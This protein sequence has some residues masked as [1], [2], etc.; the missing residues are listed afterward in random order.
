MTDNRDTENKLKELGHAI[1]TDETTL[2]KVMSFV[3]TRH[4][5]SKRRGTSLIWRVIMNRPMIKLS[6]A[7]II[8]LA[9]IVAIHFGG[10]SNVAFANVKQAVESMPLVHKT[11]DTHRNGKHYHSET[12]YA[13]ETRTVVSKYLVDGRCFKISS[14]NYDTMENYAYDPNTD[15]VKR[16]YRTDV[17]TN[18]LSDS[19]WSMV[20]EHLQE[21]EQRK[22]SV[23]HRQEMHEANE[24]DIY[25]FL[26]PRNVRKEK[27]EGEFVV[28]H[29]TQLPIL[30]KSQYWTQQGDLTHDSVLHFY[31]PES[32]P[33]DIYALGVPHSARMVYDADSKALLALKKKLLKD[34]HTYEKAFKKEQKKNKTYHLNEDQTLKHV[35]PSLIRPRARINWANDMIR[36]LD[37]R[38]VS[39]NTIEREFKRTDRYMAFAWDGQLVRNRAAVFKDGVSLQEAFKRIVGLSKFEYQIPDALLDVKIKGDWIVRKG[40]TKTQ[41]LRAFEKIAQAQVK[42]PIRFEQHSVERD[43]VVAS[44]RFRF[45]PLSNTYDNKWIHVFSDVMDTD[46]RGG[47]G[48]GTPEEFLRSLGD[49]PLSQQVLNET[50]SPQ[51]IKVNWGWH[52][53]GYLRK[54]ADGVEKQEKLRMLLDHLSQQTG[55]VFKQERRNVKVWTVSERTD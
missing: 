44:G 23:D 27:V 4:H 8:A 29:K 7:A 38:S 17:S 35:D 52:Y 47:G 21:F 22:A 46:E 10:S 39:Q 50:D 20:E 16:S 33:N 5:P 41:K 18:L 40:A 25:H 13:F 6:V 51:D 1:G 31:F 26:I 37:S 30:Y 3:A 54:V 12:W 42:R 55:L 34:K 9:A 2:E 24:V 45:T 14:L 28:N 48:G 36:H 53:S 15:T 32:G 49:I 11:L 43:V 19:P